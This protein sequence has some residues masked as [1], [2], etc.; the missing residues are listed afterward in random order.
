MNIDTMSNIAAIIAGFG[1]AALVF[2]IQ[3]ELEMEEQGEV[4]WIP[5]A[6]RLLIASVTLSLIFVLLLQLVFPDIETLSFALSRG[7]L[8]A[9]LVMMAGYIFA[10]LAHYRMLFGG[11]RTGP[12]VNPEPP[13]RIIVFVSLFVAIAAFALVIASYV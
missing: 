7:F 6:D 9:A 12:R 5:W 8:A 11:K 10:I 13:E 1:S 3:R 4:I 2:R